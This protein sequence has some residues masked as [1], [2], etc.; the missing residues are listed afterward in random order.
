M[1]APILLCGFNDQSDPSIGIVI[2]DADG[3]VM[4]QNGLPPKLSSGSCDFTNP[5]DNYTYIPAGAASAFSLTATNKT[6]TV[7]ATVT[8]LSANSCFIIGKSGYGSGTYSYPN[9]NVAISTGKLV[10]AI[11]IPGS[12][13]DG[14]N[15]SLLCNLT[16]ADIPLGTHHIAVV[17]NGLSVTGYVDGVVAVQG[18]N[19][20]QPQD[21]YPRSLYIGTRPAVATDNPRGVIVDEIRITRDVVYSGPF[22]PPAPGSMSSYVYPAINIQQEASLSAWSNEET[23]EQAW[24]GETVT[25]QAEDGTFSPIRIFIGNGIDM[26]ALADY[27]YIEGKITRRGDVAA[28]HIVA[29]FDSGFNLIDTVKSGAA[30]D[31]RF[32]NLPLLANYMIVAMD[33]STY[34]YNPAAADR[35]TPRA[36][37]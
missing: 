14:N 11:G 28:S 2:N 8:L 30:G 34:T 24:P 29:C 18:T 17:V 25:M 26:P 31:Y 16:S 32:D 9:W 37:S 4:Y 7:E 35:R 33:N 6:L 20:S 21:S 12:G 15:G 19:S 23:Q 3:S 1:T 10:V 36:Y 13:G 22:T 5:Y 27:G